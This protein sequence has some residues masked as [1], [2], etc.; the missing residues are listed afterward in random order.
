MT[1]H[2]A[3]ALS[4]WR[5]YADGLAARRAR[6]RAALYGASSGLRKAVNTWLEFLE[7]LRLKRKALAGLLHGGLKRGL[8]SWM[9]WVEERYAAQARLP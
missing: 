1:F 8:Y 2:Q 3:R 5:A 9:A 6:M 7:M 4:S